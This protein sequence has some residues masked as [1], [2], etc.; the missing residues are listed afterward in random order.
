MEIP[1]P[2]AEGYIIIVTEE[3]RKYLSNLC[4]YN[5]LLDRFL[6]YD[7]SVRS[8]HSNGFYSLIMSDEDSSH[9]TTISTEITVEQLQQLLFIESLEN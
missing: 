1:E 5:L 6:N 7:P 9:I 3:N 8:S 4:G 2:G